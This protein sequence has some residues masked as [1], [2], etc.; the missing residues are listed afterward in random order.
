MALTPVTDATGY[1]FP[2]GPQAR[3]GI[4]KQ[5]SS[6]PVVAADGSFSV[7]FQFNL[8]NFSLEA[9]QSVSVTY[10]LSGAAPLFGTLVPSGR[11][12]PGSYRVTTSGGSCAG[13]NASFD[14]P[15]DQVLVSGLTRAPNA[16]CIISV[17]L[18]VKRMLPLPA[19]IP[20]G[21]LYPNQATTTGTPTTPDGT[22]MVS[23]VSG[24]NVGMTARRRLIWT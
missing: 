12:S 5:V 1:L 3:I 13:R 4:A 24:S 14:G 15:G 22:D 17:S 20:P 2:K 6:T 7:T 9:L 10:P 11:L 19:E 23:D 16:A 18:K 21:V 8:R